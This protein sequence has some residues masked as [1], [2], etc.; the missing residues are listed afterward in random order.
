MAYLSERET[1]INMDKT[2]DKMTIYTTEYNVMHK[3]DK[4]VEESEEWKLIGVSRVKGAIV[5]KTYEAPRK[6]LCLRKKTVV[7]SDEQ[8]EAAAER[9]RAFHKKKEQE[10]FAPSSD[11]Y[12]DDSD[13]VFE[14]SETESVQDDEASNNTNNSEESAF[15]PQKTRPKYIKEEMFEPV[16]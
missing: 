6:L 13:I 9:L 16:K 8:R 15:I 14:N 2:S 5:S 12:E 7:M 10:E 11:I 3:L 4:Y 1:H